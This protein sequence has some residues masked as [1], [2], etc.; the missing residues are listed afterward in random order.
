MTF[1]V[2][3]RRQVSSDASSVA[4]S[5]T[6]KFPKDRSGQLYRE[7]SFIDR[8]RLKVC[9]GPGGSG[10][11]KINGE[12]LYQSDLCNNASECDP[13]FNLSNDYINV[14]GRDICLLHSRYTFKM[15]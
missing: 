4:T 6:L 9:G 2:L 15:W 8:V 1:R 11:P 13:H 10:Y 3:L 7:S 12:W 5:K 14:H